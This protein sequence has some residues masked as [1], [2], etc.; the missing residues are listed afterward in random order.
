ME[1]GRVTPI[2]V[3]S[4]IYRRGDDI[5]RLRQKF[6]FSDF[7]EKPFRLE[8]AVQ[9]M[10]DYLREDTDARASDADVAEDGE[11][12]PDLDL[13]ETPLSTLAIPRLLCDLAD[14]RKTGILT[15]RQD[16]ITKVIVF[17]RGRGDSSTCVTRCWLKRRRRP[18]TFAR[19]NASLGLGP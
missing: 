12:V 5:E 15:L 14:A 11:L 6:G 1:L 17:E 7:L 8:D 13:V 16:E 19:F 9:L 10:G 18:F 3:T 2:V 4:A